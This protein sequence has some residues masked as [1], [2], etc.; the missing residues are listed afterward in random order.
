MSM[1]LPFMPPVGMEAVL[2]RSGYEAHKVR[3]RPP[4]QAM[5]ADLP[6]PWAAAEKV[7]IEE[8]R[9]SLRRTLSLTQEDNAPQTVSV[10]AH[11]IVPQVAM[12]AASANGSYSRRRAS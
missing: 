9:A 2:L 12:P 8:V 1:Q 3:Q 10:A 7:R 4:P 6:K 5:P 11:V